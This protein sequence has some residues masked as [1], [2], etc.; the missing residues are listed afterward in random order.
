MGDKRAT[1]V[2]DPQGNVYLFDE[3]YQGPTLDLEA[4]PPGQSFRI[5]FGDSQ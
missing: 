2:A 1:L 3:T 4:L 5:E